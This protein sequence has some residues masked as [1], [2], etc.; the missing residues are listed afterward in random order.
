MGLS[1]AISLPFVK[2]LFISP[3]VFVFYREVPYLERGLGLEG[4]GW[5]VGVRVARSWSELFWESGFGVS[6]VDSRDFLFESTGLG[7]FFLFHLKILSL[8]CFYSIDI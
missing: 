1:L 7:F 6:F 4:D 8:V 3:F 2:V 5:E